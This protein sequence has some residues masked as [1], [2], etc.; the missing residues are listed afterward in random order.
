M[1]YTHLVTRMKKKNRVFCSECMYGKKDN[2][3]IYFSIFSCSY[4]KQIRTNYSPYNHSVEDVHPEPEKDNKKNA[5]KYF[6]RKIPCLACDKVEDCIK[7]SVWDTDKNGNSIVTH[8]YADHAKSCVKD[9][10]FNFDEKKKKEDN[11]PWYQ[12][13]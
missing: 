9:N 3:F 8:N 7:S 12:F 4:I 1:I 5:C 11:K 10:F 13:W 2:T 6:K